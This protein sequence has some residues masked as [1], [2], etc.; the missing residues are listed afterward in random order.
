MSA[1]EPLVTVAMPLYNGAPNVATAIRRIREQTHRNLDIVLS[2]DAST[3]ETPEICAAAAR[4]DDRVRYVRNERNLGMNGNFNAGLERKRGEF[5]MWAGQD[6]EKAPEF[7]AETLAA[8]RRNANASMACS[9]TTI[10]TPQ[11]E[12]LHKPYSPAI[13]SERID[14]RAAAFV[15]D[16]Q[17]VAIY[18]LFRSQVVDAIGPIDDWLDTDRHFLF[19]ALIRGPFE[20][21]PRDLFRYRLVH[22]AADYERIGMSMRPGAAD[23]D[24]DL[25]RYFPELMRRAGVVRKAV[26]RSTV[27]MHATLKPYLDRR[28]EHLI[29]EAL[30]DQSTARL[31]AWAKQYPPMLRMRMFWG[32]VRRILV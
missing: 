15:A 2:D 1:A 10:V 8:L 30:D 23:Y 3:D 18:G 29:A 14:E 12:F 26:L 17:C 31:F 28:A 5:F 7:V 4:E 21:V 13:V 20:V 22:S 19:K 6:D 24:L 25:Y 27:A 9:W 32:A 16:T 11:R